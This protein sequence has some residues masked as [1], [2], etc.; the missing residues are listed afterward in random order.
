[1]VAEA[2]ADAPLRD[3]LTAALEANERLAGLA[4]ELRAENARLREENA[5]LHERDARREAD[6]ERVSAELAVLQRLVF[7]RSS[8]RARPG[9]AG[10]QRGGDGGRACGGRPR[11]LLDVA[12]A[13]IG[14]PL[15]RSRPLWSAVFVTGLAGGGTGLVIVVN[16]VLADG[17]GGLAVLA[18]LVDEGPGLPPAGTAAV[19]FPAPGP[20]AGP[21]PPMP[22]R[23]GRDA[24]PP[25]GQYPQ[26][27]AGP[28]RAGRRPPAAPAGPDIAKPPHRAPAA[29]GCDHRRPRGGPWPGP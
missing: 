22:G 12:A 23:A 5:R 13:V 6:L 4:G 21:W 18:S 2:D 8:D 24:C 19:P 17:I 20:G 7:G 29:A 28:G 26:H 11:A 25:G 10:G 16:H 15:P 9:P 1:V 3:V 14:E 27:Q